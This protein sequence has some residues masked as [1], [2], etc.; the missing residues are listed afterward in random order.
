MI[1]GPGSRSPRRSRPGGEDFDRTTHPVVER[2]SSTPSRFASLPVRD[3]FG[4]PFPVAEGLRARLL[5]LALIGR[6]SA[7]NGLLIPRCRSVHTFGMRFPIDILFLDEPGNPVSI[8]RA[9]GPGRL[10]WD[11]RAVQV[12]ESVGRVDP[13]RQVRVPPAGGREKGAGD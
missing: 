4:T 13:G 6:E 5:G 9:V 1:S 3:L 2:L 10:L 8:H 7:G 12:L 11:R